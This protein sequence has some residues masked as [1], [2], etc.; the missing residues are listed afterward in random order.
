[1]ASG[2]AWGSGGFAGEHTFD[3]LSA[4]AAKQLSRQGAVLVLL[5]RQD[6]ILLEVDL[7]PDV[8]LGLVFG[9]AEVVLCSCGGRATPGRAV[10]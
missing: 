9:R 7:L 1:V 4:A 6:R 2:F 3:G 5:E 8:F 10:A